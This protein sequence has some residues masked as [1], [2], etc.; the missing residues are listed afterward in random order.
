MHQWTTFDQEIRSALASLDLN[1]QIAHIDSPSGEVYLVGN[2]IGL[3]GRFV[4]NVREPVSCEDSYARL[5][6]GNGDERDPSLCSS[7]IGRYPRYITKWSFVLSELERIAQDPDPVKPRLPYEADGG[8]LYSIQPEGEYWLC[9]PNVIKEEIFEMA[10]GEGHL[11]F[12][13]AWQKMRRFVVYKGAKQLREY[14]E[15]C[16][17]Y[18]RP[19][20][21]NVFANM[22]L[23][24]NILC[25]SLF[26]NG[27]ALVLPYKDRQILAHI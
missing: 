8:L 27:G 10:H 23:A 22:I 7:N 3:S 18:S 4:D 24:R 9:I 1:F 2:E 20:G 16:D 19:R 26:P 15:Q 14:I 5:T 21:Y 6:A 13:R 11:G 25:S 17:E 12:H